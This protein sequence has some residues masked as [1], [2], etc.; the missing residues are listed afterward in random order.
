MELSCRECTLINFGFEKG[1]MVNTYELVRFIIGVPSMT[2]ILRSGEV[3]DKNWF[4]SSC[5]LSCCSAY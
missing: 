3:E 2:R 4:S 5:G 1:W